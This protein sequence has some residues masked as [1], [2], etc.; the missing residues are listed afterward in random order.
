M[1]NNHIQLVKDIAEFKN[2]EDITPERLDEIRRKLE[3]SSKGKLQFLNDNP[4]LNQFHQKSVTHPEETGETS[5]SIT[6]DSNSK[7]ESDISNSSFLSN[8]LESFESLNGIKKIAVSLLLLN[9]ALF[10]SLISII[11]IYYG[12]YL[13][14]KYKIAQRFPS[15]A[16]IIHL[17]KKFSKYYLILNCLVIIGVILVEVIFCSAILFL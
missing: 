7:I 14:E 9:S 5:N 6:A 17:R 10:S 1:I 2:S 16:K 13:L 15:L 3:N 11:F 8:L 4:A 12:D